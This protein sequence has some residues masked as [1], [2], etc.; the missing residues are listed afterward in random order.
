[1]KVI[2]KI[3]YKENKIIYWYNLA[4]A[5]REKGPIKKN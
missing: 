1:M 4:N 5:N 3:G 2:F